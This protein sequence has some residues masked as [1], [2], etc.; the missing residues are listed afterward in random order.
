MKI[1][2]E[3]R[4]MMVV[5][6]KHESQS[7]NTTPQHTN[8]EVFHV[9]VSVRERREAAYQ[10]VHF[11]ADTER[12]EMYR[13]KES[14]EAQGWLFEASTAHRTMPMSNCCQPIPRIRSNLG[15]QL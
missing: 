11:D 14:T 6:T 8:H 9:A 13:S 10:R 12:A 1:G 4:A 2:N 3:M 5:R 15:I 7:G